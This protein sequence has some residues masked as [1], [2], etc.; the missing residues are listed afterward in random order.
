MFQRVQSI[1]LIAAIGLITASYFLPY[2]AVSGTTLGTYGAMADGA[3]TQQV[4]TFYFHIP[5]ALVLVLLAIALVQ[6]KNR[7]RQMAILRSTFILYTA[8]F[9][10]LAF[11]LRDAQE[12][13]MGSYSIGIGVL[14]PIVALF[15]TWFA[16][17][18]IRKDD[19]LVK[20]VDRIR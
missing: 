4:K 17:R 11:Y 13:L 12:V 7:G 16:L 6:F 9:G 3:Y 5:L 1:F 2:G 18:A 20:S 15:L 19:Q 8:T 14:F 10:L